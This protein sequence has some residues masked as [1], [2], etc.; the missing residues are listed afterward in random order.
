MNYYPVKLIKNLLE[1]NRT[2]QWLALTWTAIVGYLC[3]VSFN[4]LPQVKLSSSDKLGH[5]IFH[6]GITATW[7]LYFRI[8][9]SNENKKALWKAF[10]FSF[11]YGSLLELLQTTCTKTRTG[12]LEDVLANCIGAILAVITFSFPAQKYINKIIQIKVRK[13]SR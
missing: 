3:L 1:D 12:D 9:R 2:Y 13:E 4:D 7:F 11:F 8:S 6:F 10:L 5:M